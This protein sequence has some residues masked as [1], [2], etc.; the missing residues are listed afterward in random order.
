MILTLNFQ[1]RV[2]KQK[3]QLSK[4]AQGFSQGE[5][6]MAKKLC[7]QNIITAVKNKFWLSN[8]LSLSKDSVNPETNAL[9]LR[10]DC[11]IMHWKTDRCSI[12]QG[13]VLQMVKQ[14]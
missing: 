10:R 9:Y 1:T 14:K 6:L 8:A 12:S 11:I 4:K 7:E 5:I 2:N 13:K 3:C